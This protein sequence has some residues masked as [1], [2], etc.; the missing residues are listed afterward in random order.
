MKPETLSC[1]RAS[2]LV[3][4]CVDGDLPPAERA[5]IADHAAACPACAEQIALAE[6]IRAQLRRLPRQDA[7]PRV[8]ASIKARARTE[9]PAAAV[10]PRWRRPL[11]AALAAAVLLVAV[12]VSLLTPDRHAPSDAELIRAADEARYALARVAQLT[13]QATRDAGR[14]LS[15]R[16]LAR[17]AMDGLARSLGRARNAADAIHEDEGGAES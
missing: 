10:D 9:R 15:P 11:W 17:P 4:A 16:L 14:E 8:I 2:G 6:R 1:D 7:P 3:E 5:L 13:S 12:A